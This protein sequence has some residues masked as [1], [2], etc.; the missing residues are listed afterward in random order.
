MNQENIRFLREDYLLF[1]LLHLCLFFGKKSDVRWCVFD[2][3]MTK[4]EGVP[5]CFL[6]RPLGCFRLIT[7]IFFILLLFCVHNQRMRMLV[8]RRF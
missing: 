3:F 4:K 2:L 8:C 5:Y 7:L 6:V 1:T